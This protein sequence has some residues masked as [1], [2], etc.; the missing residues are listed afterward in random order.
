[1]AE[2]K[3][4]SENENSV[5]TQAE[6]STDSQEVRLEVKKK[7]F[8]KSDVLIFGV[9]LIASLLIWLYASNIE[10]KDIVSDDGGNPPPSDY[11]DIASQN[12]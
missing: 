3:I 5:D 6:S 10:K 7:R 12:K 9:C 4:T 8:N 11:S 1:M 2:E